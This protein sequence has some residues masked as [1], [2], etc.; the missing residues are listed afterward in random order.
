MMVA[1]S[2]N[3]E[4]EAAKYESRSLDRLGS[5]ARVTVPLASFHPKTPLQPGEKRTLRNEAK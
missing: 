4:K 2:G 1:L 5:P 3:G